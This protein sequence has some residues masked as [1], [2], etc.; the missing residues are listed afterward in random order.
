MSFED[1]SPFF[2]GLD[3]TKATFYTLKGNIEVT[4]Y[5]DNTF[6]D[7]NMGEAVMLDT[8]SPRIICVSEDVR[9]LKKPS[10]F[11]GMKV[12]I[13]DIEYSLLQVQPE[14]TGLSTISL[15]HEDQ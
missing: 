10:E 8:T 3:V 13:R 12:V 11:R 5:F 1:F 7:S 6:I 9:F 14:G 15:A 4:C 2:A